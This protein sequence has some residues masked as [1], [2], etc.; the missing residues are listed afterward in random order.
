MIYF[1]SVV[2][3]IMIFANELYVTQQNLN[4]SCNKAFNIA[5]KV[6]DSLYYLYKSGLG[7]SNDST[8]DKEFVCTG[9]DNNTISIRRYINELT[10]AQFIRYGFSQDM[11]SCF[12][13]LKKICIII[14]IRVEFLMSCINNYNV[15]SRS[16]YELSV[17]HIIKEFDNKNKKYFIKSLEPLNSINLNKSGIYLNKYNVQKDIVKSQVE[18]F[19]VDCSNI[20]NTTYNDLILDKTKEILDFPNKA[21]DTYSKCGKSDSNKN[22][23]ESNKNSAEILFNID[24][25]RNFNQLGDK[26]KSFLIKNYKNINGGIVIF[27]YIMIILII[28]LIAILVISRRNNIRTYRLYV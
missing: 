18:D 19:S 16:N 6:P 20:N 21:A 22:K 26:K 8:N 2:Q 7:S 1:A 13:E 25:T 12:N 4:I 3:N 17:K 14:N 11:P 10:P 9:A 5:G 24:D 15:N 27:A 28:L 23:K